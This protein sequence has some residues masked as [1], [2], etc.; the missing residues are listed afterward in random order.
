MGIHG[1]M[2][3]FNSDSSALSFRG[4]LK[5]ANCNSH[6][7]G[8]TSLSASNLPASN[9]PEIHASRRYQRGGLSHAW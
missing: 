9:L 1:E 8:S 4:F 7:L 5:L 2:V 6:K 3:G